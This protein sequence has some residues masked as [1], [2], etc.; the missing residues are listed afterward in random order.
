MAALLEAVAVGAVL[1]V[2]EA[3]VRAGVAA[4]RPLR[5]AALPPLVMQLI[6]EVP[7]VGRPNRFRQQAR[8]EGRQC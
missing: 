5:A 3:A 8:Q 2:V 4:E 7:G 1:V 6:S